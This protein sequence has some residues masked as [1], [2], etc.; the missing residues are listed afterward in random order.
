MSSTPSDY[1]TVV[2]KLSICCKLLSA[3]NVK[4]KKNPK[5]KTNKKNP[6]K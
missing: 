5:T 2:V 1:K 4:K 3:S 6:T